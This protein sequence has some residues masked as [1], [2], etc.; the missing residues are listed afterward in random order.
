ME[1]YHAESNLRSRLYTT[2]CPANTTHQP[3]A[4]SIAGPSSPALTVNHLTLDRV[5]CWR[6]VSTVYNP[7]N[8]TRW[9]NDVLMLGQRRRRWASVKT[10]LFQRVVFAGKL[11]PI[12]CLLN[13]GPASPVLGSIHSALVCT[14]CWRYIQTERT[15]RHKLNWADKLSGQR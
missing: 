7:A 12:Q 5:F 4:G 1:S 15:H 8:T 10:S 14:S 13:V 6:G 3:N 9:N 2:L 11:T